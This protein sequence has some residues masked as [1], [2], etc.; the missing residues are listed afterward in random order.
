MRLRTAFGIAF[1]VILTFLV[2]GAWAADRKISL[3]PNTDLPGFDYAIIKGTKLDACQKACLD[4]NLC[5]AFTFSGKAGWC[6]LKGDVGTDT[7]FKGA[8]S[9]KVAQT[10]SLEDIAKA[11]QG[12]IPFPAQDL[13][14]RARSF[15]A[16]LKDSNP[17]PKD[18][19]YADLVAQADEDVQKSNPDAA[20]ESY[21]QAL[22]IVH[23]DPAVWL[24]LAQTALDR[25]DQAS[26]PDDDNSDLA[27]LATSAATNA[28]LLSEG[29]EDR[30]AA[31][32]A[33]ARALDLGQKYREAIATYRASIALV[34]DADLGKRLEKAVSQHGFRVVNNTV[35][36][37]SPSP[38]ICI[39]FATPLPDANTDLSSYVVVE[40]VP[41]AAVERGEQTQI[42]ITGVDHG[43]RYHIKLRA[44]LPSA[45][46]ETLRSDVDLNLFVPDRK[47]LV[48]FANN[49]YVMPAG[50]GGG[51]PITSVNAQRAD[52]QVYRIGD[53]SMAEAIRDNTFG[54]TLDGSSAENVADDYG[55]KI[56]NGTVDLA[57]GNANAETTTAIPLA[58]I[59][60]R[61]Q[62]GAYVITAKVTGTDQDYWD[63]IATQWFIVTDLGLTTVSGDDGIHAFI[64]SL[65]SAKPVAGAKVRLVARNNEVLGETTSDADGK[66]DFAP[67]LARGDGGR[68]PLLLVAETGD[69][70]YSVLD[71]S[72]TAFDLTDRGVDGRAAPG[73]LDLFA[74]T[75]RGVYRPGETVFLTALLR[76][77]HA[78]A[79]T[80]VP[81][82]LEMTRPDGVVAKREVLRDKGAGGYFDALPLVRE[83]MRGSWHIRLYT[84]PKA[85]PLANVGFLV[86]DFEPDRLAFEATAPDSPLRIGEPAE[87]A[88]AARYLYGA[89]APNLDIEAD[90]IIRAGRTIDAYPGYSFG[91]LDDTFQ[92]DRESLGSVGTTDAEGNATASI[93]LPAL[94]TATTKPLQAD[95]IL[96]L[97]DTNGR[98]VQHTLSRPVEA[99]TDEIG[100]KPR[101]DENAGLPENSEAGFDIIDV[102]PGGKLAA[103]PGLTWTL[104]KITTNYQWYKDG[105]I[106]KW[107]AVTVTHRVADG[108]VDASASGPVSVSAHVDSGQYRFEIESQGD[109]PTSTTYEFYAGYYYPEAGSDTPDKLKVA[110]DKQAYRAGD[111]AHLKLEPQFAGTALVMVVDDR[112]VSMQA[113]E[114]PAGGTTVDL[115]VTS[116]WSPGVYVTAMLYTPADAAQKRMP[117]RALGLAFADVDPGDLNLDTAIEAPAEASPRA[118]LK[119]KVKLGNVAAGEKAYV[120]VAAVDV[121]ILNLTG[122]KV[123]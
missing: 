78:K 21:K 60:P 70:D 49:A 105:G 55:E 17:P 19:K 79:V 81:L 62:P 66:A 65:T 86:E 43:K 39:E 111:V 91:R 26:S 35:D 10:P 85:S 102:A 20:I 89:T 63:S 77:A 28:L 99:L 97:V 113:V 76:D 67:G 14:D 42:C 25:A 51:L 5:R 57:Q 98:T 18:A 120:A 112:I 108:T 95:L 6:F 15:A 47:P 69:G 104:S 100:V 122:F 101:F 33:L 8:T 45:D 48:A 115:P 29:T 52:L 50:L 27:D 123:P 116:D 75:E 106:W 90:A 4:D 13:V 34:D 37:E 93:T 92:T 23:N 54:S 32:G 84:D 109:N 38:R 68:A 71:L 53:R 88:I 94:E 36:S 56:W 46:G 3:A 24:R 83:A 74:T 121:G 114:V 87:I 110:L 1:A 9:G 41:Q 22:A 82:T 59:A 64:R 30:A 58:D 44:G 7:P 72:R 61:M 12:E 119:A 107:E 73:P 16:G 117:S 31:L 118:P 96:S 11:R 2:S 80:A 40:G 103:N